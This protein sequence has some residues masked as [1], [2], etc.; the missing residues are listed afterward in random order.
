MPIRLFG[1]IAMA[2][3]GPYRGTVDLKGAGCMQLVAAG[4]VHALEL[5]LA[6][7]NTAERFRAAAGRGLY[8]HDTATEIADA[9]EHLLRLR[10]VHQLAAL[11][12]GRPATNRVDPRMLSHQ[13][14][15]L[16]REAFRT[17]AHVQRGLRERFATDFVV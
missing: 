14:G 1:G 7:T 4:R 9:Y 3:S 17:V 13:D 5:G 8:S 15:V 6:E 11:R 10:L 12:A 16:L 2:R